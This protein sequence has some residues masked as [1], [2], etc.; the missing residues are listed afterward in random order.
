MPA[1]FRSKYKWKALPNKLIAFN[2][3]V[4]EKEAGTKQLKASRST[5]TCNRA[6]EISWREVQDISVLLASGEL[7]TDANTA[8]DDDTCN[9]L[10]DDIFEKSGVLIRFCVALAKGICQEKLTDDTLLQASEAVA[11]GVRNFE[12]FASLR[13]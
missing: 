13:K 3:F 11:E 2:S 9:I 4:Q 7:K 12:Q 6:I 10:I 8:D 1:M 5:S